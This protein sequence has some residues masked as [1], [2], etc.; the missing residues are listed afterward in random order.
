MK[1][2]S[3][4]IVCV[5]DRSGSMGAI[6]SDAVGGFNAF[7]D[8]Q[9]SL[10]GEARFTLVLF[11]HDYDLVH[12]A[13]DIQG[14]PHLDENTYSPRGTTALLDAIGRTI[15]DV[16][17]RLS[18]TPEDERPSRVIVSILTDGLENASRDYDNG[19]I[20]EMISHQ[21]EKY[22]WEF[23][24]LAANQ[25]AMATARSMSIRRENTIS[26]EAT[27]DGIREAHLV[28]SAHF[29]RHRR[30]RKDQPQQDD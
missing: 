6:R 30:S 16:G 22:G 24:F 7:L 4:E 13:T 15:D 26:Y 17:K 23:I 14:V 8:D 25:D 2:D 18:E 5:L 19:R 3:T 20:S 9:K 1:K 27:P 11:D 10:P 28:Q 12:D 21:Q 29:S